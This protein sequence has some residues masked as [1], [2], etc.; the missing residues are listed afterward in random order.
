M[1]KLPDGI[2][3]QASKDISLA[4]RLKLA[5]EA[6]KSSETGEVEAHKV[7]VESMANEVADMA[8]GNKKLSARSRKAMQKDYIYNSSG[9][10]EEALMPPAHRSEGES[11]RSNLKNFY[12]LISNKETEA[13]ELERSLKEFGESAPP[14]LRREAEAGL[15]DLHR[16]I[17]ELRQQESKQ[18]QELRGKS[19]ETSVK[20]KNFKAEQEA[21]EKDPYKFATEQVL[22]TG[23]VEGQKPVTREELDGAARTEINKRNAVEQEKF[24]QGYEAK[25]SQAIEEA[26][27][28]LEAAAAALN[29][30]FDVWLAR[31]KGENSEGKELLGKYKRLH[32]KYEGTKGKKYWF[33]K[34]EKEERDRKEREQLL[35]DMKTIRP[36]QGSNYFGDTKT[37]QLCQEWQEALD[38]AWHGKEIKIPEYDD[39]GSFVDELDNVA[40]WL[41]R[42]KERQGR[43]F[44]QVQKLRRLGFDLQKL[45]EGKNSALK[46]LVKTAMPLPH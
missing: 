25:Q 27:K 8:E 10:H 39:K 16:E 20:W 12:Q 21:A 46:E 32:D 4:A 14:A 31:L 38:G 40:R 23:N 30:E 36:Y 43:I 33:G 9:K 42:D 2:G 17:E 3:T 18:G 11:H 37:L 19:I 5:A 28:R 29:T 35:A 6:K 13:R 24:E 45:I 44:Q 41:Y 7:R 26:R 22:K 1:E 34:E 15:T